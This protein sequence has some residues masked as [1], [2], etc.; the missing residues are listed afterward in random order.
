[1]IYDP[2]KLVLNTKISRRESFSAYRMHFH[3]LVLVQGR[4]DAATLHGQLEI[5]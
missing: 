2:L 4:T 5:F 3:V 1:M